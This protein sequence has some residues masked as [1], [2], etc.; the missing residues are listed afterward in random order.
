M[1]G[2][3]ADGGGVANSDDVWPQ[4]A[5]PPPTTPTATASVTPDHSLD[6]ATGGCSTG[7]NTSGA[8]LLLGLAGLVALR[9]RPRARAPK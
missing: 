5:D 9:R 2:A 6:P 3:D 7:G 4:D 8:S 1:V